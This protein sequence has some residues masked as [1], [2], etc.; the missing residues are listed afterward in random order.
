MQ[1]EKISSTWGSAWADG[2]SECLARFAAP[3]TLLIFACTSSPP[4]KSPED[5]PANSGENLSNSNFEAADAEL[6]FGNESEEEIENAA[7]TG[8]PVE[9][10][11]TTMGHFSID[12]D[13][14]PHPTSASSFATQRLLMVARLPKQTRLDACKDE[15][16][17]LG[18]E[19]R[20]RESLLQS[21]ESFVGAISKNP[22]FYHW[23]FYYSTG[24]LNQRLENAER[25]ASLQALATDFTH[26]MKGLWILARAL[27][28]A[29]GNAQY[30]RFLRER[31]IE[32]SQQYFGRNLDVLRQPLGEDNGANAEENEQNSDYIPRLSH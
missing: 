7:K 13:G 6:N 17:T 14:R 4:K 31:Y 16:R 30:F 1:K 20:S 25:V 29:T 22:T 19:I 2:I 3:L 27:E 24:Q 9:K 18:K 11:S 12:A 23:C 15:L 5:A 8:F 21:E 26:S 32:A 28:H 10:L